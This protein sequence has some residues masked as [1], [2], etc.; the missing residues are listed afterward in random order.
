MN[1]KNQGLARLRSAR[2][3][4]LTAHR[5]VIQHRS[6]RVP[7]F[8]PTQKGGTLYHPFVLARRKGLEPPT[9]WFVAKHSIQLS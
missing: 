8:M 6:V 4:D 9:F 7:D 2:G 1:N 5:A 3:T